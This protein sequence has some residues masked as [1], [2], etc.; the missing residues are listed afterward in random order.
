MLAWLPGTVI[1]LA[2]VLPMVS[3]GPSWA[4]E[5]TRPPAG[6]GATV[7]PADRLTDGI[8]ERMYRPFPVDV[9]PGVPKPRPPAPPTAAEPPHQPH[10]ALPAEEAPAS[11]PADPAPVKRMP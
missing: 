5:G 6:D 4:A 8:D 10:P 3:G 9:F 1:A 11:E 2:L 7:A